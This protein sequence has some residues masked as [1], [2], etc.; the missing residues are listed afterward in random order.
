[1]RNGRS[2]V[3][4]LKGDLI[5]RGGNKKKGKNNSECF[6]YIY[7][8]YTMIHTYFLNKKSSSN[9]IQKRKKYI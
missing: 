9:L 3:G 6:E 8:Y 5:I 4:G 1:M 7:I 2:K